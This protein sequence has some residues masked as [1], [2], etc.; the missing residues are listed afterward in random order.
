MHP[1][2]KK[3]THL[4]LVAL[5]LVSLTGLS[6]KRHFCMGQHVYSTLSFLGKTCME[7]E[8]PADSPCCQDEYAHLQVI[9]K[10][11]VV[12]TAISL[13]APPAQALP[14]APATLLAAKQE[15]LLPAFRHYQPPLIAL[16]I[17]V[18]TGVFLI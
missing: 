18:L 6:V 11:Q 17:P 5:I 13:E 7:G 10:F 3:M 15:R 12:H 1:F 14:K 9:E 2:A 8:M 4:S 16:D